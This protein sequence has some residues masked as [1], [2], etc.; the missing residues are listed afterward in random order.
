M[1]TQNH[2]GVINGFRGQT[3]GFNRNVL[4]TVILGEVENN[5]EVK[6]SWKCR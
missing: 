6:Y 4:K 5:S 1:L 3:T 2:V